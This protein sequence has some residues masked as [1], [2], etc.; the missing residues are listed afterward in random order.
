LE[1]LQLSG[2]GATGEGVVIT[3]AGLG[4]N[5]SVGWVGF[6]IGLGVGLVE[7]LETGF[8]IGLGVGMLAGAKVGKPGVVGLFVDA[9]LRILALSFTSL[10]AGMISCREEAWIWRR[11]V[12]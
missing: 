2:E 12:K 3:G 9:N 7:G 8:E 11:I 5:G 1:S 4:T 6:A 10:L